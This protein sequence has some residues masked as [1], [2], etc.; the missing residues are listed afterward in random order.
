MGLR[1][2]ADQP[3]AGE[4]WVRK[5]LGKLSVSVGMIKFTQLC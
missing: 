4:H 1:E 2:E 5:C 3:S